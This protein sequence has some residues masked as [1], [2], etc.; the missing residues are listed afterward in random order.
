M[1]DFFKKIYDETWLR[2]CDISI[3]LCI[4]NSLKTDIKFQKQ[5]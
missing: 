1:K 3:V 2:I 5:I 4:E